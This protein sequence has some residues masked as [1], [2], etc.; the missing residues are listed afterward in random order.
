[1]SLYRKTLELRPTPR[2]DLSSLDGL[3][4]VLTMRFDQRE[5]LDEAISLHRQAFES[6]PAHH[7]D[8]SRSLNN[9]PIPLTTRFEQSG[10]RED[11]DK[12]NRLHRGALELQAAPHL[13]RSSSL[14]NL[15]A[16]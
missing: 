8:R 16:G 9:P 11:L 13:D 1:M 6:Q 2:A 14:N 4:S 15:A 10:Y 3:A 7:L 12:A 5:N